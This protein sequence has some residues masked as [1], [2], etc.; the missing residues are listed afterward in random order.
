MDFSPRRREMDIIRALPQRIIVMCI[1]FYCLLFILIVSMR[2][3]WEEWGKKDDIARPSSHPHHKRAEIED[4]DGVLNE[5]TQ[6]WFF[7]LPLSCLPSQFLF[8]LFQGSFK[9]HTREILIS[10]TDFWIQKKIWLR[11]R[12]FCW[13]FGSFYY[14]NVADFLIW[15][16]WLWG[17]NNH[18]M[19]L[20]INFDK[21]S[22][23]LNIKSH[24]NTSTVHFLAII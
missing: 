18:R 8:I 5:P 19:H 14:W 17:K 9:G 20:N 7:L 2:K 22:F 10:A 6:I 24:A 13:A 12:I 23:Y 3:A 21:Y 15:L 11:S 4:S 1:I 16:W